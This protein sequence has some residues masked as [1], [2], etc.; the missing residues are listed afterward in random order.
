[1]HICLQVCNKKEKNCLFFLKQNCLL[2]L[3]D[4]H[5]TNPNSVT[6]DRDVLLTV[7]EDQDLEVSNGAANNHTNE[8]NEAGKEVVISPESKVK[9]N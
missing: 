8:V 7:E 1:M 4:R 5:F 6:K 3:A 9:R 2:F